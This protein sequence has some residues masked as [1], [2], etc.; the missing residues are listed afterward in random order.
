[1]A[2]MARVEAGLGLQSW[3]KISVTVIH[4]DPQWLT[5]EVKSLLDGTSIR[6]T[7]IYG[8][9]T[10]EERSAIWSYLSTQKSLNSTSPWG[11]LGDFNAII[12]S[13][14]RQGGDP[15]WHN[16]MDDFS[17]CVA[18]TELIQIP[19]SGL[20]F[21]WHNG[22]QGEDT[23][24]RKIDWAWGNQSLL[25]TW[26]LVKANFQARIGSDHS[27]ILMSLSPHPPRQTPRFKFLNL[28]ADQEG[29]ED[30]VKAA[31]ES[32]VW[33][34]PISRLTSKLR[35]LKGYLKLHHGHRTNCISDKAR[36]AKEN[37]Q[38]AQL[39]LDNH[40]DDEEASAREWEACYCYHNFKCR[41]GMLL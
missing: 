20:H 32:E 3:Q 29:Y 41:R 15:R 35:I 16:H 5:C 1:M 38:A 24:L 10:Q 11:I 22:R 27:P 18:Q 14:D 36:V 4:S 19:V 17:N 2:N 40:P 6:T 23:I 39:H 26:P 28:W 9:N 30:T 8:L 12:S 13:R 37:W 31:W 21:T 7:F 33:G 25:A 34:N